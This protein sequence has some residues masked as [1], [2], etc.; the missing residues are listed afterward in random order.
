MYVHRWGPH[1]VHFYFTFNLANRAGEQVPLEGNFFGK[2]RRRP[3][4]MCKKQSTNFIILS[5]QRHKPLYP[6]N[7]SPGKQNK[8]IAFWWPYTQTGPTERDQRTNGRGEERAPKGEERYR[9]QNSIKDFFKW[10]EGQT[11]PDVRGLYMDRKG[12][13]Q[14]CGFYS[15]PQELQLR[16]CPLIQ[17]KEADSNRVSAL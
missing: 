9:Q 12:D 14:P 8:K 13:T 16:R 7:I 17:K 5:L 10:C 11:R 2:T 3:S 6:Q 1:R 4:K 15:S